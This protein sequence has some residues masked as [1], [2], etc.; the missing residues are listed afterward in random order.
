MLKSFFIALVVASAVFLITNFIGFPVI[1]SWVFV[2]FV[3][4]GWLFLLL[5]DARPMAMP[6]RPLLS[7]VIFFLLASSVLFLIGNF[8][9]QY[10][11]REEIAKVKRLQSNF[12]KKELAAQQEALQAEMEAAGMQVAAAQP[13]TTTEEATAAAPQAPSPELIAA[14]ETVYNDFECYNCHKIGGKGGVKRRGPALDNVGGVLSADLVREKILDPT[15]FIAEGFERE[16][17]KGVMPDTYS[18]QMAPDSVDAL[19]AYLMSLQD[20]SVETP[21]PLDPDTGEPL[22]VQVAE[23]APPAGAAEEAP[24]A[25]PEIGTEHMPEGWWTDPEIIAKGKEVYEG[26]ANPEVNCSACHGRDG[27]PV[28]TGAADFRD[29]ELVAGLSDTEW[30]NKVANGVPDTPMTAWG[31]KLTVEQI[32]QVIAYQNTFHTGGKPEVHQNP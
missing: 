14:G 17:D 1:F 28:L 22:Q 12:V 4:I 5:L 29:P 31:E 6:G 10:D 3:F 18:V 15:V 19:V 25:A 7:I 32:W 23:A 13:I 16:Y 8:V 27:K 9:P 21:R 30:F 11:P 20:S 26:V 24:A 2:G